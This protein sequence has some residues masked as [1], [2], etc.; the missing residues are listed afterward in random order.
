MKIKNRRWTCRSFTTNPIKGNILEEVV[1][2]AS[3]APVGMNLYN[4]F[5]ITIVDSEN[6]G[7]LR[8]HLMEYF[9]DEDVTYNATSML[10]INVNEDTYKIHKSTCDKSAGAIAVILESILIKRRLGVAIS[11]SIYEFYEKY[12]VNNN[13]KGGVILKNKGYIPILAIFVGYPKNRK[14]K[15]SHHPIKFSFYSYHKDDDDRFK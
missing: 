3:K 15:A 11:E 8:K 7:Y 14:N 6:V 2:Y 13:S 12:K 10:I 5:L 1:F 9:H 4:K